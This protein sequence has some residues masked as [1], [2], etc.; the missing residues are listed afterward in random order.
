MQAACLL[1][2]A[3]AKHFWQCP[4][5]IPSTECLNSMYRAGYIMTASKTLQEA[6]DTGIFKKMHFVMLLRQ[7][8]KCINVFL[9]KFE[10]FVM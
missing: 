7:A 1:A 5:S 8:E 6:E 10:K 9:D 2:L 4:K 3:L